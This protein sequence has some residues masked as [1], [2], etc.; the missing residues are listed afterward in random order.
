MGR[1]NQRM[2]SPPFGECVLKSEG[3]RAEVILINETL[4]SYSLFMNLFVEERRS[5]SIEQL[6]VK[7]EVFFRRFPV[8]RSVFGP[9]VI[10]FWTCKHSRK[11]KAPHS[12]RTVKR[13]GQ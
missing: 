11:L 7:K 6:R 3:R 2:I 13:G 5:R 8:G 12:P 4:C 1:A 9:R 10:S